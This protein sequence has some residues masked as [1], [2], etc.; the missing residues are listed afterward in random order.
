MEGILWVP[1]F[2]KI[3]AKVSGNYEMIA[4]GFAYEVFEFILGAPSIVYSPTDTTTINN[5]ATTLF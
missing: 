4:A 3:W 2:E 1:F 5:N